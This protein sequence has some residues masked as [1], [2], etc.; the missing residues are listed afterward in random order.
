MIKQSS[1]KDF[2]IKKEIGR[3]SYGVAYL[4][5]QV[6]TKHLYVLKRI[7][8][9]EMNANDKQAAL[10]EVEILKKIDHPHIIKYYS[11]YIEDNTLSIITEYAEAGD[12]YQLILRNRHRKT[13]IVES[14]L[15]RIF[16]ELSHAIGYL[17]EN[18]IVHRDIKCQN[19]FL[20]KSYRVKLGDFGASKLVTPNM[21]VTG[22]GTPLYLAPEMVKQQP[23]DY[24]VDIWGLG[25]IMYTLAALESP[26]IGTNLIT[27]GISIINRSPKPLPITYSEDLNSFILK[28]LEK[29]P[30]TRP[31]ITQIIKILSNRHPQIE[32]FCPDSFLKPNIDDIEVYY[33]KFKRIPKPVPMLSIPIFDVPCKTTIKTNNQKFN[34]FIKLEK[35]KEK[36]PT[37]QSKKTLEKES[38]V[39]SPAINEYLGNINSSL[40]RSRIE[41]KLSLNLNPC[42]IKSS[43][44]RILKSSTVVKINSFF[45]P[46]K[47]YKPK[48][49]INELE[50]YRSS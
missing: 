49:T 6:P 30:G 40:S 38:I 16:K 8:L 2:I 50:R 27:L 25:C 42:P 19:V 31:D 35:I 17:H 4:V 47:P 13:N 37:D 26:F 12:L 34:S 7:N 11:S 21:Q 22:V 46:K 48:F 39:S 28:L 43:I 33:D 10:Q 20:T 1:L 18:N 24:K 14:I 45:P 5:T 15:W 36:T 32:D 29:D 23:Y 9:G 44:R 3:G 41:N